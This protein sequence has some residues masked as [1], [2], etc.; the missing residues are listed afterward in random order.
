MPRQKN[1]LG[2][3]WTPSNVADLMV[4]MLTSRADATI[5]EPS[6]GA[7]A[8]LDALTHAGYRHVTGIEVDSTLAHH[9][10]AT[11]HH[12]SFVSWQPSS[13]FD[14]VIGNPPYIRWRDLNEPSRQE[15]RQ[16]EL[17]GPLL[18]SLTDYLSV[19]IAKS[20]QHLKP[21]GELIFVTPS[22]WMYTT[23]S[24]ALRDWLLERGRFTDIVDFG[25]ARVFPKVSSSIIIFRYEKSSPRQTR[26]ETV[27]YFRY[28]H[29]RTLPERLTLNDPEQFT[30]KRIPAF[31]KGRH[32]T[33]A[34]ADEQQALDTLEKACTL[35]GAT[36][37]SRL[38]DVADIANGMISGLDATFH[39]SPDQI[40]QLPDRELSAVTQVIKAR[41][42]NPLIS[43]TLEPYAFI[44]AGLT[45]TEA[46][47]R[48]PTLLS[49]LQP[50]QTQLQKRYSHTG[51]TQYWEWSFPR[52]ETF[53]RNTQDKIFVPSKERLTTRRYPRF[54][55]A[56]TG[57][58]ATQD[59]TAL[60]PKRGVGESVEYFVAFLS[61]PAVGEWI[62]L[63]GLMK[64]GVAEF[65]EGPL[66]RIPVRRIDFTSATEKRI[67]DTVTAQV[68]GWNAARKPPSEEQ[69]TS[70]TALLNSLIR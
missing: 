53:H 26:R 41:N 17:W 51:T 2:Q 9:P 60:A 44:P 47:N 18:N 19:F 31:R 14:A 35:P 37:Y 45:E 54:T 48:Y 22:N 16:N 29:G 66:A 36:Q 38:G 34:T 63:R 21:G 20:A 61:L 65:S 30:E 12:A 6:S 57:A 5:L 42:I 64:G 46:Q 67:H 50:Q 13:P 28:I 49:M 68:A 7:G 27:N 10:H 8:L 39:L 15:I 69:W 33:V 11:V 58:A 32:W 24:A 52:S 25:E 23:H 59:V 40:A 70:L 55:L 56:P 1:P 3:Y 62:R 4:Q 43:T